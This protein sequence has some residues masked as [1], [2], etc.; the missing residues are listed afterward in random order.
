MQGPCTLN[1][2]ENLLKIDTYYAQKFANLVRM[3]ESINED[4]GTL[5]DNTI[6]FWISDASDGC[7]HN[8]NNSPIIQAGSGG[9]YFKTG[10]IINLD[11]TSGATAQQMLG[12]SLATCVPGTPQTLTESTKSRAP[13]RSSAT[14]RSTSTS[15]TS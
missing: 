4:G 5:L 3:L 14:R 11:A 15:A 10:K 1:A 9:G 12:R 6:A 7:A 13:S 8:L 2:V